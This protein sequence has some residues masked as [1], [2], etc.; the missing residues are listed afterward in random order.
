[1]LVRQH[2][3]SLPFFRTRRCLLCSRFR[4]GLDSLTSSLSQCSY[5]AVW[6]TCRWPLHIHAL[7]T[8]VSPFGR[9]PAGAAVAAKLPIGSHHSMARDSRRIGV[10]PAS[11]GNRSRC[12]GPADLFSDV[13]VGSHFASWNGE[14]GRP[15]VLLKR[16]SRREFLAHE[17]TSASVV[18]SLSGPC[19][20]SLKL[21]Q[22][23]WLCIKWKEHGLGREHR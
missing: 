20:Q 9:S 6:I 17:P 19:A 5:P 10:G 18:F 3:A 14:Q 21:K 22:P 13:T 2:Q 15:H 12:G 7:F 16:G 8:K 1:M 23:T 4:C 11:V